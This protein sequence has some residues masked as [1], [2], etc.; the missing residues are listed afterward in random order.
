MR[1]EDILLR[2]CVRIEDIPVNNLED[3]SILYCI[4]N[5]R[6]S[7]GIEL[8]AGYIELKVDKYDFS[9]YEEKKES[10]VL[11][12]YGKKISI[13]PLKG[14][15]DNIYDIITRPDE[16]EILNPRLIFG[17]SKKTKK[18]KRNL[19]YSISK[20]FSKDTKIID[21]DE[22]KEKIKNV[23]FDIKYIL[24]NKYKKAIEENL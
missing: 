2:E 20:Y 1:L 6:S 19:F 24:N 15:L 11:I 16:V 17:N 10:L 18:I 23:L 8:P 12:N 4:G 22:D 13:V 21:E 5:Y 9:D 3:L 14:E 7:R